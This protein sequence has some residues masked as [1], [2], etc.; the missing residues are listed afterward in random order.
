MLSRTI[1]RMLLATSVLLTSGLVRG[2]DTSSVRTLPSVRVATDRPATVTA[3][4][5]TQVVTAE[6]MEQQ[7]SLVLSDV[8]RQL[9]GITLKDYGGVGGMKT[10]SARGLGSQFSTLTIDGIAVSDC[11]NGQ[12]DL[13]RYMLG[14]AAY[15]GFANGQLQQSLQSARSYAA[16]NVVEMHT[17]RPI[18]TGRKHNLTVGTEVGSFGLLSPSVLWEQRLAKRLTMSLW[19]NYLRSDGDY[20]FTLYYTGSLD[21]ST[22]VERRQ[23]SQMWMATVDANLFY[24]ISSQRQLTVKAHWCDGFRALP[25]P[26]TLYNIKKSEFSYSQVSF[27]QARYNAAYGERWQLQALAKYGRSGDTYEDTASLVTAGGYLRNEYL[28]QE[29]YVSGSVAYHATQHLTFSLASDES[30]ASLQSNLSVN[31]HVTRYASQDVLAATYATPLFNLNAHLLATI[32]DEKSN[33]REEVVQYRRLSPYAGLSLRLSTRG[34]DTAFHTFRLR[35]FFKENYRIPNFNEMYY[36]TLPRDL[37]PER[38]LQHNVGVVMAG[39][40]RWGER[41]ST[42]TLSVDGYYNRVSDK[43]IAVRMM[44]LGRVDIVGLE[45]TGETELQMERSRLSLT[46]HYTYQYAV[47]VSDPMSRTYRHQIPYTPRHS[48]GLSL[49]WE[50]E[51]VEMGYQ[52]QAVGNRYRLG[53]NTLSTLVRGYV[54]QGI[55]VSKTFDVGNTRLQARAQ[56]LNLFDVQYEVVKNYPMMGRNYRLG[57]TWKF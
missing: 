53:E 33:S 8:V 22:S 7:G 6:R 18:L 11:Q 2:Q 1:Y 32:V 21:D 9:P 50:T 28:Q 38:A 31:N 19:A 47:D 41:Q 52:L 20:P 5:P 3:A 29:G 56:V 12:I 48:G 35:Y 4:A 54:D 49:H 37:R 30:V 14:N 43:I 10:V 45:A 24:D 36:F 26:V 42:Y 34:D 25:G 23:N 51:W 27:V 17:Q 55:I 44:N 46:A 40:S 15:V 16:G 13:G 57:L 39:M